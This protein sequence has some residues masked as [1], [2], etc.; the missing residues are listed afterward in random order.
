MTI[1]RNIALAQEALQHWINGVCTGN[2][3]P[4]LQVVTSD[5]PFYFA[6]GKYKNKKID[7]SKPV[8]K[9]G[10]EE[11]RLRNIL[12]SPYT[13]AASRATVIFEFIYKGTQNGKDFK[14]CLAIAFD[15][16]GQ[17]IA[18]CREYYGNL[19]LDIVLNI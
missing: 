5:Y 6:N 14:H 3:Q 15:I 9:N 4:Y 16:Q 13:I 17:K 7:L 1:K 2:W 10:P 11:D 12:N 8:A 19:D 18:A